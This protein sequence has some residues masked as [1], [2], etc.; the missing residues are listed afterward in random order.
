FH[1]YNP[2][3]AYNGTANE[4]FVV[5][6]GD[7]TTNDEFEIYGQ[8]IAAPNGVEVGADDFRISDMGPDGNETFD[9]QEPAVAYNGTANEYL[10]AWS[11]DDNTGPLENEEYEIFGQRLNAP[12]GA[13]VGANDVRLSDMG[14]D[15][16]EGAWAFSP[17]VA[18]NGTGNEYLVVWNGSDPPL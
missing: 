13:E 14:P 12:T 5:W 4:Y 6:S 9:A 18:F 16:N 7:D 1:A 11:G 17:A 10:V 2:A 3:V 15:G 8:R